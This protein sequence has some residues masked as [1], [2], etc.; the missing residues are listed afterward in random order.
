MPHTVCM[1]CGY[2]KGRRVIDV[3]KKETKKDKKKIKKE[4][5]EAKEETK[6]EH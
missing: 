1:N 3:L 5:K 4:T 2:Y 6:H